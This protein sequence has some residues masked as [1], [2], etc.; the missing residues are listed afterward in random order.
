MR[1]F[2]EHKSF[3]LV[4]LLALSVSGVRAQLN[5][6]NQLNRVLKSVL[7]AQAN[8]NSNNGGTTESN[9]N[10]SMYD[11][12]INKTG[13]A[14]GYKAPNMYDLNINKTGRITRTTNWGTRINYTDGYFMGLAENGR[15]SAGTIYFHD[16]RRWTCNQFDNNGK[17]NGA[18]V[19]EWPDGSWTIGNWSHG[20]KNG[21]FSKAVA[22]DGSLTYYD[23]V[24]SNGN[25]VSS[26]EVSSPG[27]DISWWDD[28]PFAY[29]VSTQSNNSSSSSSSSS[30]VSNN[31]CWRCKGSGQCTLCGGSGYIRAGLNMYGANKAHKCA[32]CNGSGKCQVC[33]GRGK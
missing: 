30:R 6:L 26:T 10:Y 13:F 2:I 7:Q 11:L 4:V 23:E 20:Y 32:T 5:I 28:N 8:Q 33:Y 19:Q 9:G 1:K 3:L 21:K 29:D 14:P 22:N 31:S 17:F 12:N 18:T 27:Q 24:W 25:C 16:G 15:R